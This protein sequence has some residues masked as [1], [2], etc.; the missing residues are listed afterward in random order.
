VYFSGGGEKT[1]QQLSW[2]LLDYGRQ[3]RE[4]WRWFY[5]YIPTGYNNL[6][7]DGKFI[8]VF[9]KCGIWSKKLL[10]SG[11]L[12][13]NLVRRSAPMRSPMP[14]ALISRVAFSCKHFAFF[15]VS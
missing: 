7:L 3:K 5:G 15:T 8:S 11:C 2:R 10:I 13:T 9:S 14:C 6:A 4:E 12:D 1:K